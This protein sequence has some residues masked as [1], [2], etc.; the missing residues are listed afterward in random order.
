MGLLALYWLAG[1][2]LPWFLIVWVLV[3]IFRT[4]RPGDP[5]LPL[6]VRR[7]RNNLRWTPKSDDE[8]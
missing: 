6:W 5:P 7:L 4:D 3:L 1:V 8:D 2:I